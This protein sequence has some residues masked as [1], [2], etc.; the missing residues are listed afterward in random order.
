[1][2]IEGEGP[3]LVLKERLG[4]RSG[5]VS[6]GTEKAKHHSSLTFQN[7]CL[8]NQSQ[9][10]PIGSRTKAAT[11]RTQRRTASPFHTLW[12]GEARIKPVESTESTAKPK[13]TINPHTSSWGHW[14]LR[15]KSS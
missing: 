2:K 5:G 12:F 4:G 14:N 1:M 11:V 13:P 9:V 10:A 8:V 6:N 15:K 3:M 7:V